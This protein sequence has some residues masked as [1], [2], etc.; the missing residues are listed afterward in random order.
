M[1]LSREKCIFRGALNY[2]AIKRAVLGSCLTLTS[3]GI[4]MIF[5]G[6][7][8]LQRGW[9]KDSEAL[10]WSQ[11]ESYGGILQ[12]HKDLIAKRLDLYNEGDALTGENTEVLVLDHEAKILAI[13]RH[14]NGRDSFVVVFNFGNNTVYDYPV[15]MH[16][17]RENAQLV[18]NSDA[19]IYCDD[20]GDVG[21]GYIAGGQIVTTIGAYACLLFK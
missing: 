20:F 13:S 19:R 21:H 11:A 5:Q 9:F 15:P 16:N 6:Q 12:L 3:A 17:I 1:P 2:F 7:E 4:P 18:F 8:F 14:A 10:A